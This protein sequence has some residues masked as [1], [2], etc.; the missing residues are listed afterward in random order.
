MNDFNFGNFIYKLRT[1]A[2]LTQ[3]ELASQ[4]GVTNKAVSK[5]ASDIIG[6]N[7]AT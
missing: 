1:E 7:R 3:S 5:C 4:V 6:L 2:G